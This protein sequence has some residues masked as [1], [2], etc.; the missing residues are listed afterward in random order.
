MPH[1]I[2]VGE[3]H[4][5]QVEG[6]V[7]DRLDHGVRDPRCAHLR[8]QIVSRHFLR[9]HQD[10]VLAGKRLFNAAVE[11]VGHVGILLRFGNPQIAQ[12]GLGQHIRQQ[13]LHG[14]GQDDHGQGNCLS[15]CVMHT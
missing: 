14:L 7:A 12:I 3:I 11:E 4:Y 8:G 1:H 15:Y 10:P 9:R 6:R 13:I 2:G 5:H